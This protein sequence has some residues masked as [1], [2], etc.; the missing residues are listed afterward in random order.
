MEVEYLRQVSQHCCL[1][2]PCST[3]PLCLQARGA[4]QSAANVVHQGCTWPAAMR[5]C[6]YSHFWGKQN[7]SDPRIGTTWHPPA[8]RRWPQPCHASPIANLTLSEGCWYHQQGHSQEAGT[9]GHPGALLDGPGPS[10]PPDTMRWP[11]GPAAAHIVW[12]GRQT[13]GVAGRRTKVEI[14]HPR[15]VGWNTWSASQGSCTYCRQDPRVEDLV[16]VCSHLMIWHHSLCLQLLGC[17]VH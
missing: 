7:S 17:G 9:W 13:C 15:Y 12:L 6:T 8:H 2:T 16:A 11:Q 5:L 10:Q 1:V 14:K 3:S 4:L